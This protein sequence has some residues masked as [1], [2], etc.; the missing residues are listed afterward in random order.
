M[1]VKQ[2]GRALSSTFSIKIWSDRSIV[3]IFILE[4]HIEV[5]N[6]YYQIYL[7]VHVSFNFY[8]RWEIGKKL[9]EFMFVFN[10]L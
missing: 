9:D 10:K 4:W 1:Q 5:W 7:W 6:L 3:E 2:W 8:I